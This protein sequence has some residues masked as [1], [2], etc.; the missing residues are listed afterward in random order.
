MVKSFHQKG[1]ALITALFIMTM[2]AIAATAMSNRLHLDIFRARMTI[3]SDKMYLASQAV[4]FWSM[5]YLSQKKL[6]TDFGKS[7]SFP[8]STFKSIYPEMSVTG[9]L[10]DL[11]GKFNINNLSN[12]KYI[13]IFDNLLTS[14]LPELSPRDRRNLI[15]SIQEW[16]SDYTPG[17]GQNDLLEFYQ[18]QNPPYQP[19]YQLFKSVSELRLI[20]GV[21]DKKFNALL[22]YL[23]ALPEVTAININAASLKILESL[24]TDIDQ[25]KAQ[26]IMSFIE[27]NPITSR[28][29]LNELSKKMNLPV[30]I[31]TFESQ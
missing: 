27:E 8:A 28:K 20:K 14:V 31:L 16:I 23:T 11:Q 6:E 30:Q 25:N 22:P 9:Y 26:K 24:S 5:D 2:I 1:S 3:T 17:K 10:Y 19:G 13:I 7:I 29:E 4:T 18:T 12:S 21:D 15:K